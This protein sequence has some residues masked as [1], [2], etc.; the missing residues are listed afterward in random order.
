MPSP[1]ILRQQQSRGMRR[2]HGYG[3]RYDRIDDAYRRRIAEERWNGADMAAVPVI[4]IDMR[5]R[6]LDVYDQGPLASSP[7]CVA[8]FL[9]CWDMNRRGVS[10]K[11]R[12]SRLFI[13]WNSRG[14]HGE[15]HEDTG[16]TLAETFDAMTNFGV[17]DE[18]HWPYSPAE[19]EVEPPHEAFSEA[20]KDR[21]MLERS[22][23]GL[24]QIRAALQADCPVGFGFR[25]YENF[26]TAAS[27]GVIAMP[28]SKRGE[29][30]GGLAAVLV[31]DVPD[32]QSFRVRLSWGEEWGEKGYGVIP[33][34]YVLDPELAG[35][36]WILE[37]QGRMEIG[38]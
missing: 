38:T 20:H 9:Y 32:I 4:P 19:L 12:P 24:E 6:C 29:P 22:V 27:D 10:G 35:D 28:P 18:Q 34:D 23:A 13:Y 36:L 8:A 14:V 5:E 3:W 33:Y 17:A 2:R 31:G 11:F 1:R 30:I 16:A 26:E 37:T 7:A 21:L 15:N 25:V